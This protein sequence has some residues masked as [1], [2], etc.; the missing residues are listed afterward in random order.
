MSKYFF[1]DAD[2]E[3][4]LLKVCILF[5]NNGR[6]VTKK[7]SLFLKTVLALIVSHKA[8]SV[9]TIYKYFEKKNGG[10][11]VDY[12]K[13]I[14]AVTELIKKGL[15]E[16][17]NGLKLSNKSK[18]DAD[19]YIEE[20]MS[21]MDILVQTIL[22]LI[23]TNIGKPLSKEEQIRQNIKDCLNC[24]FEVASLSF[25]GLDNPKDI[26]CLSKIKEIASQNLQDNSGEFTDNII[27]AIGCVLREPNKDSQK[28]I[29]LLA[30]LSI[31]SKI[32]G[33]DPLLSSFKA[34]IFRNKAFILDTEI[35]LY[36]ITENARYSQQY[37]LLIKKLLDNQCKIYV[38]ESVLLE[39][40]D[41]AEAANK[42][43]PFVANL[44]LN[45][46]K[47]VVDELD[48]VFVEDYYYTIRVAGKEN[49]KWR[50][51]ISN[52]YDREE[53]VNL[54]FD[55]LDAIIDE[56]VILGDMPPGTNVDEMEKQQLLPEA[57]IVTKNTPKGL[58]RTDEKN[59]QIAETDVFLYL[60]AKSLNRKCQEGR[61]KRRNSSG[62][63]SNDY[64]VV[65][66]NSRI[67]Y[68]AKSL[69]LSENVLCNP[70][71]LI[72]YMAETG[73]LNKNEIKLSSLFDNI[74]LMQISKDIWPE[75]ECLLKVGVDIKG[76]THI[77]LRRELGDVITRLLSS[78]KDS[79]YNEVL[80]IIKSR[81]YNLESI[82]NAVVDE[83]QQKDIEI[84]K[85]KREL[86]ESQKA[87][88]QAEAERDFERQQHIRIIKEREKEKYQK[89][90]GQFKKN[91][92]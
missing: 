70:N 53:G 41:H 30:R 33:E 62:V 44:I 46:D 64:Y 49:I 90:V 81:G 13:V 38:P 78:E 11:N 4:A 68:C 54:I 36:L 89:R 88:K 51:Y 1:Q 55:Q 45:D 23:K 37:R 28:I 9:D 75:I 92:K 40:Y 15:V 47:V 16:D 67:H 35:M 3:E 24:Y 79:D 76:L 42:R 2:L 84:E 74:F 12:Q 7:D 26:N 43:Y 25:L 61:K 77:K 58:K 19:K 32:I 48:N 17:K 86:Q 82:V 57:I 27:Y 8:D 59:E 52:F 85:L 5:D 6:I 21:L 50:N 22:D 72:A 29:D 39:V 80:Q 14:S 87:Q 10:L 63:L 31:T 69:G 20:I 34:T 66:N 71:A 91:H 56:R 60:T 18:E 73:I 83:S 65:S